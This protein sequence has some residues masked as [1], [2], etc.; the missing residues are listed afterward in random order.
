M[1]AASLLCGFLL[2]AV[3]AWASTASDPDP[4]ADPESD[5]ESDPDSDPDS[6]SDSDSDSDP[7][8]P[9]PGASTTVVAR[10]VHEDPF[11]A[12][13]EVDVLDARDLSERR[14]RTVPEALMEVPG[15][16][17]QKTNH[18]GGSPFVRGMTGPQNL[19]LLDGVRVSNS[20][21]RTGPIQ[22]LNTVDGFSLERIE[23]LR[24]PGS[25]LYGSDALGGVFQL[26]TR[27]P[28][29]PEPGTN[30][31]FTPLVIL[32]GNSADLERSG[33][34]ALSASTPG[35]GII[36][37]ATLRTFGDLR[38]GGDVGRQ[39]WS[40]YDEL[41]W[42]AKVRVGEPGGHKLEVLY[43]GTRIT[44]AGR[45][46]KLE[47]KNSLTLYDENARDLVYAAGLLRLRPIRTRLTFT[48]SWQRQ[49]E[50]R[51]KIQ[52]VDD[53][54]EATSK[55]ARSHD[56][57]NTLG[58]ALRGDTRLFARRLDLLYGADYYVDMV[59]SESSSGTSDDDLSPSQPTYPEG[60][61]FQRFGLYAL[62]TGTPLRTENWV[63]LVVHG[64]VRLASFASLAPDIAGFGDV[65][66]RHVGGVAAAGIHLRQRGK[67][68]VG[69]GFDQGFRAPNLSETARIGDT[70]Q[71]F[72]IPATSLRPDRSDTLEL[73]GRFHAGPFTFGSAGYVSFLRDLVI[74]APAT[75]EGQDELMGSP[76][77]QHINAGNGRVVGIEGRLGIELPAHLSLGGDLTWT[78]GDYED[79]DI[80]WAPMSRIPPLF[81]TGRVRFAPPWKH[82]FVEV[83]GQAAGAQRR[84]S[85][86]DETDARIP[87]N[88]TDDWWTLNIR[89]GLRPIRWLQLSVGV[90][91][92]TDN[93]YKI[94]GSG[95]YGSGSSL[96][97]SA[98]VLGG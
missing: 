48:P 90:V 43:Q 9:P 93:P 56:V 13:R 19:I 32:R 46:D 52:F 37:G 28:L 53:S 78:R 67:F 41:D 10:G 58:M 11:D 59:R 61:R 18:A 88:G 76:V 40:G 89:A 16:F 15:A 98:E 62:A 65:R 20:T 45:T 51:R 79:P 25:V 72:Q 63:E 4:E 69:V 12:L 30:A 86:Q 1:R 49:A 81:G 74:R 71:W 87:E 36:G 60:S 70:G 26:V 31:R 55:V 84:L 23:L 73:S 34:A 22:Y 47:T 66:C 42:D 82:L 64:G 85:P 29:P 91:N 54:W 33:R 2:F 35:F 57:V 50:T 68:A 39:V 75:L 92:L 8:D 5:P 94:H 7:D 96:W 14:P 17:V 38:G 97:I 44:D 6:N 80:G 3:P 24:G 95:V 83:Y 21:Y 77:V 27:D